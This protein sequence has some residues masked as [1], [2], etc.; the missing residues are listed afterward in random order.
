MEYYPTVKLNKPEVYTQY[1]SHNVEQKNGYRR[2]YT[3]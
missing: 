1:G 2:L 3:V